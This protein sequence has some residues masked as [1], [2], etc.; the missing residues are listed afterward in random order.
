MLYKHRLEELAGFRNKKPS[1]PFSLEI[2][3]I[4]YIIL[5]R[6]VLFYNLVSSFE[7]VGNLGSIYIVFCGFYGFSDSVLL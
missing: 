4:S 3:E 2:L 7:F 6:L 5:L 1:P